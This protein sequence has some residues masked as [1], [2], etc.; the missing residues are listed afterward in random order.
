VLVGYMQ[1]R[2][3]RRRLMGVAPTGKWP[4][5]RI[6]CTRADAAHWT[7]TLYCWALTWPPLIIVGRT[8]KDGF[9]LSALAAVFFFF[10]F[11]PRVDI[12]NGKFRVL[13]H[14]KPTACGNGGVGESGQRGHSDLRWCP[15]AAA[16]FSPIGQR[17]RARP[18]DGQLRQSGPMGAVVLDSRH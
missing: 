10:F 8:L 12:T 3:N 6:L 17:P 5:G 14:R 15:R 18:R 7:N 1:D 11:S 13:L 16:R 2:Q 4:P 9:M